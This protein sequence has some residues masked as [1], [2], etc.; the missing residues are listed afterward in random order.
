MG[1]IDLT[2]F[3]QI[4]PKHSWNNDK[5][6]CVGKFWYLK[7]LSWASIYAARL[8]YIATPTLDTDIYTTYQNIEKAWHAF[9]YWCLVNETVQLFCSC[10]SIRYPIDSMDEPSVVS[11]LNDYMIA[12]NVHRKLLYTNNVLWKLPLCHR[13]PWRLRLK[14][15]FFAFS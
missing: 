12:I 14:I 1:Y 10:C 2:D 11:R 15:R 9:V 7:Y 4:S 3:R 6:K 8:A 13:F 5:R